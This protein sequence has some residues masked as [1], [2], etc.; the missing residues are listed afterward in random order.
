MFRSLCDCLLIGQA[1]TLPRVNHQVLLTSH[2]QSSTLPIFDYP[3]PAI[4]SFGFGINDILLLSRALAKLYTTIQNAPDDQQAVQLDLESLRQ[5]VSAIAKHLPS[6]TPI[7]RT[8]SN[9]TEQFLRC[10][11]LL[12]DLDE[13]AAV[14]IGRGA[15]HHTTS[16]G[17][18]R[19]FRWGLYKRSEFLRLLNDL[20]ER[21][22]LLHSLQQIWESG[23]VRM[24]TL[25]DAELP[26]HLIDALDRRQICYIDACAT[27][28]VW[29]RL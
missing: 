29:G 19:M 21:V 22:V 5:L 17:R 14:Y 8:K 20:R 28:E 23:P 1:T 9:T 25:G 10:L 18:L 3:A 24:I 4:M 12:K 7:S 15:M 11:K 6:E 26:I 16:P 2:H 13:I 27:W